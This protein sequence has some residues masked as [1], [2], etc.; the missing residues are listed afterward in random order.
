MD[1]DRRMLIYLIEKANKEQIKDILIKLK[2]L[3]ASCGR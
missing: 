1:D 2:Q 3:A